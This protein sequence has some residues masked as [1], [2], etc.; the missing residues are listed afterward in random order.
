MRYVA[1]ILLGALI[2]LVVNGLLTYKIT[3][4]TGPWIADRTIHVNDVEIEAKHTLKNYT[5]HFNFSVTGF[6]DSLKGSEPYVQKM[7]I[8][9]QYDRSKDAIIVRLTPVIEEKNRPTYNGESIP[10]AYHFS[11]SIKS[12]RWGL[13]TYIIICGD[14]EATYTVVVM[15]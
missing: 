1:L 13:N 5:V 6:M 3:Y 10:F 11:Y 7:H 12:Y 9:E 15:K 4:K 2:T 8:S 14:K